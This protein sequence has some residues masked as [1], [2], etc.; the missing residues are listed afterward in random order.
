MAQD[1]PY[2]IRERTFRFGVRVVKFTRTM[3]KDVA[4]IEVARQ[5][6]RAGTSVGANTEEADGA[7]SAKDKIHKLSI[8]R[9]EAKESCFWLRTIQEAELTASAELEALIMESL[10]LAKILSVMINHLRQSSD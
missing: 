6:L 7:E 4:G 9:K 3:P 1:K 10:E 2:D 8:A 5:L